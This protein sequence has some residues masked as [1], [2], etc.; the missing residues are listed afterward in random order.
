MEILMTVSK[1]ASI[2]TMER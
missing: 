1:F 2:C